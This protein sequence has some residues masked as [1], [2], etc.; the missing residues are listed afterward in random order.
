VKGLGNW[1]L[2]QD[3]PQIW[4]DISTWLNPQTTPTDGTLTP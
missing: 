4:N 1:S 2:G 3:N